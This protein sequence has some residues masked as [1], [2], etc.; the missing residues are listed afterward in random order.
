VFIL[1]LLIIITACAAFY[2]LGL[3]LTWLLE[4]YDGWK[5]VE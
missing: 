3:C 1:S 2:I 4:F 5:E